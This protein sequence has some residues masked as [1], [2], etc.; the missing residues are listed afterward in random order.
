V[1]S[2]DL[3]LGAAGVSLEDEQDRQFVGAEGVCKMR[4]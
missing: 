4:K 3:N 1:S 2:D